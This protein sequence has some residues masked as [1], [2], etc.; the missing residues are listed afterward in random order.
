MVGDG[1]VEMA[2]DG[3]HVDGWGACFAWIVVL[4]VCNGE[5]DAVHFG[6]EWFEGC[7]DSNVA[8]GATFRDVVEGD[9]LDGFGAIRAETFELVAPTLLPK[10]GVGAFE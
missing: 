8:D 6:F 3:G 9:G 10:V 4:A 7:D 5:A 1:A 2:F